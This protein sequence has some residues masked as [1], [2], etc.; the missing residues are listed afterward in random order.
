LA[1]CTLLAALMDEFAYAIGTVE[2]G[3]LRLPLGEQ[4]LLEHIYV[5]KYIQRVEICP[6]IE[7]TFALR[8]TYDFGGGVSSQII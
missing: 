4:D 6:Q 5:Y 1:L 2:M 7:L 3:K 8:D